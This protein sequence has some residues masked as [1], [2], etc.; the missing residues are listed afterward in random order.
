MTSIVSAKASSSYTSHESSVTASCTD[1]DVFDQTTRPASASADD[2]RI[3]R[4]GDFR[5]VKSHLTLPSKSTSHLGHGFDSEPAALA[6]P[7]PS[8]FSNEVSDDASPN[9]PDFDL[10]IKASPHNLSERQSGDRA[11]FGS[12]DQGSDASDAGRGPVDPSE[13]HDEIFHTVDVS[14][15]PHAESQ[16]AAPS[17]VE[18]AVPP[19]PR[20][21]DAHLDQLK[22]E[23]DEVWATY[24]S[25]TASQHTSPIM[26][27]SRD[28]ILAA[29]TQPGQIP[30]RITSLRRSS[31][32]VLSALPSSDAS[33][34]RGSLATS[35]SQSH[36]SLINSRHDVHTFPRITSSV[37]HGSFGSC[38][39][40]PSSD[41]HF[42]RPHTASVASSTSGSSFLS[43][44]NSFE[45]GMSPLLFFQ[46]GTPVRAPGANPRPVTSGSIPN[47]NVGA[48]GSAHPRF[49]HSA[50]GLLPQTS[51]QLSAEQRRQ[52]VRRTK[53]LAHMLGE[54]ML[55]ACNSARP[56]TQRTS[57]GSGSRSK[58]RPH[59]MPYTADLPMA[60]PAISATGNKTRT[61]SRRLLHGRSHGVRSLDRAL[62][63]VTTMQHPSSA[64][65]SLNRKAAAVLGIAHP[66]SSEALAR[67]SAQ[68]MLASDEDS[69]VTGDFGLRTYIPSG[70]EEFNEPTPKVT[71]LAAF[72]AAALDEAASP[73]LPQDGSFR[74]F[75]RSHLDQTFVVSESRK[76]AAAR[77]ERRRRVAK[78]SRW[79]GEA[80]P[81]E[82]IVTD[83]GHHQPAVI[84]STEAP[85]ASNASSC[86]SHE[87]S[88]L[89]S[90]R[91]GLPPSSIC[92]NDSSIGHGSMSHERSKASAL[93]SFMSIDSSDDESEDEA[94]PVVN[95]K[96]ADLPTS[97]AA[98]RRRVAAPPTSEASALPD[99]ISAYRNSI[100]S[101]EYLLNTND[102]ERLSELASIFHSSPHATSDQST[103]A[104]SPMARPPRS[105]ARPRASSAA[106]GATAAM[107]LSPARTV[108][109]SRSL[110]SSVEDGARPS[111]AFLELTDSES[112]SS[113]AEDELLDIDDLSACYSA[114][115]RQKRLGSHDRSISKLSN[116]FGSTPSQIVRSQSDLRP[117]AISAS[118]GDS[119]DSL[120]VQR[121]RGS[122]RLTPTLG[123]GSQPDALKS[124]LR[125]LEEEALDDSKLTNIQKS[126]ISRKVY[127]LKKR[128]TKMFA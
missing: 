105:S 70:L 1:R 32:V 81:A 4:P 84:R 12:W 101:W 113:D 109:A 11:T 20:V 74:P 34:P 119:V 108:P 104:A 40:P 33:R 83:A 51:N 2:Y 60:A 77:D 124:M 15:A 65:A 30:Q 56:P 100:E 49:T 98:G 112:D 90:L 99:G 7:P 87:C 58:N 72:S 118:G 6:V 116:F 80:V 68:E 13:P 106:V 71:Q 14:T 78:M 53:K 122:R 42:R 73:T 94:A 57:A 28:K 19:S 16:W 93:Q 120:A 8:V 47:I 127:L 27:R 36:S 44:Q 45:S 103:K 111:A 24:R 96:A 91:G 117:S 21:Q 110:S 69:D 22:Q 50:A 88:E 55:L 85:M 37:S 76:L 26:G 79:L 23:A 5:R 64:P 3:L 39:G 107:P 59:S 121:A 25:G 10:V 67:A 82:L 123:T 38:R 89:A 128:T 54:E 9:P 43:H 61:L 41:V 35:S 31:A 29:P 46:S 75:D 97:L 86:T 17:A 63:D 126:E 95:R 114:T 125:S 62:P 92:G 18:L 115:L 48:F 102:H 66:Y 52:Q